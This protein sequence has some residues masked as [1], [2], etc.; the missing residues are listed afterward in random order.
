MP[1]IGDVGIIFELIE[2]IIETGRKGLR[3]DLVVHRLELVAES[4][5]LSLE[6]V[7]PIA[8]TSG[9]SASALSFLPVLEIFVIRRV[10]RPVR[11]DFT[12]DHGPVLKPKLDPECR[13]CG[14]GISSQQGTGGAAGAYMRD[15]RQNAWD[16]PAAAEGGS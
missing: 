15:V 4:G 13:T 9:T 11:P 14:E 10:L 7:F 1:I 6:R 8:S 12:L 3:G 5:S 2:Q 16:A